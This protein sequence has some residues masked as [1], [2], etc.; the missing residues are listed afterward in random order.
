MSFMK[1]CGIVSYHEKTGGIVS[2]VGKSYGV[3]RWHHLNTVD[4]GCGSGFC[5]TFDP[6]AEYLQHGQRI[7]E[8]AM[9]AQN[10]QR[11]QEPDFPN[12]PLGAQSTR[13]GKP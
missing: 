10:K 13:A 1:K 4:I 6:Q 3:S 12:I 5:L 2:A 8:S 11:M 7:T 9:T